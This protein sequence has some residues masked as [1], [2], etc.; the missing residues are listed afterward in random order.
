M[1]TGYHAV[2]MVV[3]PTAEW[4]MYNSLPMPGNFVDISSALTVVE[5]DEQNIYDPQ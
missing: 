1:L 2:L 5:W 3:L 4:K